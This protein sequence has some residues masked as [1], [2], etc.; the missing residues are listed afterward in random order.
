MNT[1]HSLLFVLL[2]AAAAPLLGD[3]RIP[4]P[5]LAMLAG[6]WLGGPPAGILE[7][8]RLELNE[9]GQGLLTVQYLPGE[10][11]VAYE[12][13]GARLEQYAIEFI[14]RTIDRG[15][16]YDIY[17]KGT[18]LPNQ[19]ELEMGSPKPDWKRRLFV[20]RESAVRSRIEAVTQAAAS[21]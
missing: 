3:S 9:N 7:Y 17:L 20:E 16:E 12:I 4:P 10:P 1:K 15:H 2:I 13:L 18:A 11:V 8:V 6:Q 5:K 19:L 14:V 21:R